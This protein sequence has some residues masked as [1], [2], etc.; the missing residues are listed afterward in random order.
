M[1]AT[2]KHW[3]EISFIYMIQMVVA[4]MVGLSFYYST[5]NALDGSMVLDQLANG[6]D[7]TVIMDVL[8][9]NNSVLHSTRTIAFVFLGIYLLISILLH[10]GWLANIKKKK[11]SLKSLLSDGMH[12]F[13]PFLGIALLSILLLLAV[14]GVLGYG[15]AKI[16]GDPLMTFSSEK[17][18]VFWI[19]GLAAFF[20][21]CSI[22]IWS[23]SVASRLYFISGETFF[24]A[25]KQGFR[26]V[27][28]KLLKCTAIG[29][30]LIGIHMV[31]MVLYYYIMGDRGAPS[32][33]IV[34]FGILVQQI[35]AFT[36]V[37]IRGLGYGLVEEFID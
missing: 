10:A 18:L 4:L 2:L 12:F 9:T 29:L 16:V 34:I 6:F 20:V 17:P 14:G 37:A 30:L 11:Y 31:M 27:V 1:M 5:R 25:L 28:N 26:S 7:R 23:W 13:F 35:L 8:N 3:R 36:R 21:L 19:F 32:W 24:S 33:W 15:F 22:L